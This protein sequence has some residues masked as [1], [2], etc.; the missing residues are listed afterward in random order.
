MGIAKKS[1]A[2]GKAPP[3]RENALKSGE[4]KRTSEERWSLKI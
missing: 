2:F 3:N 4:V 1:R